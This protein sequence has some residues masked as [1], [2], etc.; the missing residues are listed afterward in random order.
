MLGQIYQN[1]AYH[2]ANKGYV[3]ERTTLDYIPYFLDRGL[4]AHI[5]CS[6]IE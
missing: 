5:I 6:A 1:R 2:I 3:A 4:D